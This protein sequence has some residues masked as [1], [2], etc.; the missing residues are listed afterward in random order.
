MRSERVRAPMAF[1]LTALALP[2]MV[3]GLQA[4]NH[5]DPEWRVPSRAARK[6]NPLPEGAS[7][8]AKGK[9]VYEA[10]CVS[11]HGTS[12]VGDGVA[13]KDLEKH[14]GDLTSPKVQ[15]QSD[16]ALFWKITTGRAPM[17]AFG[18]TLNVEERWQVVRFIRTF[19]A[20]QLKI[21]AP[22][23]EAPESLRLPLTN[24]QRPYDELRLNLA[25]GDQKK[26]TAALPALSSAV[27]ELSKVDVTKVSDRLASSWKQSTD[28][29]QKAMVDM[30]EVSS[31]QEMRASFGGLSSA[32]EAAWARFGHTLE[33]PLFVFECPKASKAGAARWVQATREPDNPYLGSKEVSCV[34]LIRGIA[35]TRPEDEGPGESK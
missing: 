13:A 32:T 12:G 26:A 1:F 25:K 18:D 30:R 4:A 23:L 8:I 27:E 24:L 22:E 15:D 3:V 33:S 11:C 28:A 31:V 16:G 6:K 21:L 35:A 10:Q 14:P 7:V 19:A 29:L 20:S 2:G 5:Q 9:V 34:Q 17:T